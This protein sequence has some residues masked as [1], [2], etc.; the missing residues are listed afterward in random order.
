MKPGEPCNA[1]GARGEEEKQWIEKHFFFGGGNK[2]MVLIGFVFCGLG[3]LNVF[4]FFFTRLFVMFVF[5]RKSSKRSKPLSRF[6]QEG[7]QGHIPSLL[8]KRRGFE[9]F[10]M[11]LFEAP[12]RKHMLH[13]I[14]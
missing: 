9:D 6:Q 11:V 7:K 8:P 3:F 5:D 12:A 4:F 13:T 10:C 2:N 14:P 1:K